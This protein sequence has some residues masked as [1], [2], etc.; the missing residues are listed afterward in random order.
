MNFAEERQIV[1]AVSRHYDE[2]IRCS[3][4]AGWTATYRGF[5][6]VDGTHWNI[7]WVGTHGRFGQCNCQW[8]LRVVAPPQDRRLADQNNMATKDAA[9]DAV[10]LLRELTGSSNN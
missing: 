7:W 8:V 5:Q 6:R 9:D 10:E 4:G 2:R 1:D 3:L